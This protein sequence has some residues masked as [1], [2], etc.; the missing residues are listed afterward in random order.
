MIKEMPTKIGSKFVV[1]FVLF[2]TCLCYFLT[3]PNQRMGENVLET[4]L[5]KLVYRFLLEEEKPPK[6]LS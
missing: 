2:L 6:L 3:G 1:S 5:K 4:N